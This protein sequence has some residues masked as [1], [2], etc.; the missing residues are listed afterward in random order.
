MATQQHL[1]SR[2]LYVK[3]AQPQT[4]FVCGYFYFEPG[5]VEELGLGKLW[6]VGAALKSEATPPG[7]LKTVAQTIKEHYY[8]RPNLSTQEALENALNEAN[9]FLRAQNALLRKNINLIAVAL[10]GNEISFS[11]AG[12]NKIVLVRNDKFIDIGKNIPQTAGKFS[13]IASGEITADDLLL[14]VPQNINASTI[15]EVIL[16]SLHAPTE[17]RVE[18]TIPLEFL[19][20]VIILFAAPPI[21][22]EPQQPQKRSLFG[23]LPKITRSLPHQKP[24]P[25][26]TPATPSP[27]IQPKRSSVADNAAPVRA[28]IQALPHTARR[29]VYHLMRVVRSL[30]VRS[31]PAVAGKHIIR[32]SRQTTVAVRGVFNADYFTELQKRTRII[33]RTFAPANSEIPPKGFM[34]LS[35]WKKI[36]IGAG[37]LI[38]IVGII[39]VIIFNQHES[40]KAAANNRLLN[41]AENAANTANAALSTGNKTQA[42]TD[43]QQAQNIARSIDSSYVASSDMSHLSTELQN[44]SDAIN[45][46][47]RVTAADNI[48]NTQTI[49]MNFN[50]TGIIVGDGTVNVFTANTIYSFSASGDPHKGN[51]YFSTIGTMNQN[52][53][54]AFGSSGAYFI[55]NTT[56]ARFDTQT[57]NFTQITI[58]LGTGSASSAHSFIA[59]AMYNGNTYLLD[60][61][62]G[63]ILKLSGTQNPSFSSWWLSGPLNFAPTS[64]AVDG[65]VYLSSAHAIYKY[66][67]GTLSGELQ[68]NGFNL[69][70][71]NIRSIFTRDGWNNIYVLADKSV[72][73]IGKDG[74]FKQQ[75]ILPNS[76]NINSFSLEDENTLYL[77]SN[78]SVYKVG[79]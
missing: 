32:I 11:S 45:N 74:T 42:V 29:G 60:A 35:T 31:F 15:K 70:T 18:K 14:A 54:T 9:N 23:A 64:L 52:N 27:S 40:A 59:G 34:A 51:F 6:I 53:A 5:N 24:T 73:V 67:G 4:R 66:E 28:V 7:V 69:G 44:L 26:V 71:V 72:L 33:A 58:P 12:D 47:L 62:T 79:L 61:A 16:S 78:D 19:N 50:P 39:M 30:H 20:S 25:A 75:I 68:I 38:V 55:N 3:S 43:L 22:T 41:Q 76:A 77:L 46:V 1:Q 56:L 13:E 49:S 36:S 17:N 37:A 8:K 65:A 63:N 21:I 57:D 48:L 10:K 2:Y